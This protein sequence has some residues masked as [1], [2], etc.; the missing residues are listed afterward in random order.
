MSKRQWNETIIYLV[1][2]ADAIG[3]R[4][5]DL[6]MLAAPPNILHCLKYCGG[7]QISFAIMMHAQRQHPP[8]HPRR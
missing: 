6:D 1:M 2:A 7:L 4:M 3:G 8:W 5:D